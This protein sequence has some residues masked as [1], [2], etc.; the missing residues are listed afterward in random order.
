MSTLACGGNHVAA[1]DTT[2]SPGWAPLPNQPAGRH[3]RTP[4]AD[5]LQARHLSRLRERR[6]NFLCR[7][8]PRHSEA[9]GRRSTP[10]QGLGS[11]WAIPR[12][13]PCSSKS[14]ECPTARPSSR[15][16]WP[17]PRSCQSGRRPRTFSRRRH[18][19]RRDVPSAPQCHR[20]AGLSRCAAV[21]RML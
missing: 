20:H 13:P 18:R 11:G 3:L 5:R 9:S 16:H 4:V 17:L 8:G 1:N 10:R 15:G 7:F 2:T 6:C 12:V 21:A 14:L 19:Y